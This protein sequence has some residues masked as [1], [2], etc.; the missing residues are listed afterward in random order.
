MNTLQIVLEL[1]AIAVLATVILLLARAKKKLEKRLTETE[2]AKYKKMDIN[3]STP[4]FDILDDWLKTI[5]RNVPDTRLILYEYVREKNISTA[6][7]EWAL[8]MMEAGYETDGIVQLAGEDLTMNPFEFKELASQIFNE[9]DINVSPKLAYE[10]YVLWTAYNVINGEMTAK[11]GFELLT[12]AAVD[13][14]YDDTFMPFY[15]LTDDFDMKVENEGYS[16]EDIEK[17]QQ[18]VFM[19]LT[20]C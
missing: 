5:I 6:W 1:I 11:E 18:K 3:T 16:N 8:N 17:M 10:Q 9:L 20:G 13:T 19:N 15:H 4:P 14:E 2:K 7:K 12:T